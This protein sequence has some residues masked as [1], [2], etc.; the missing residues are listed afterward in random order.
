MKIR[1]SV[2]NILY[3]KI[4]DYPPESGGILGSECDGVISH[5][6]LDCR[7]SD[8]AYCH[9]SPN[10]DFLNCEIAKWAE[11]D[12]AFQGIFHTH[13]AGVKTLSPADKKY[14]DRI[15]KA[16]PAQIRQLYF[17][18]Y[19]LPDREIVAYRATNSG[20]EIDISAEPLEIV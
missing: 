16:M 20:G 8:F 6:V 1:L 10:I 9:Y 18:I 2:L 11:Q 3:N 14:I 19:V 13:F 5:I 7:H 15:M 4:S 12:I 17:P